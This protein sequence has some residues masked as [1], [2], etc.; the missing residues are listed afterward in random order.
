MTIDITV[1]TENEIRFEAKAFEPGKIPDV[2]RKLLAEFAGEGR[3]LLDVGPAEATMDG[4]V[5]CWVAAC[6]AREVTA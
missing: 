2:A 3:W 1:R 5:R 6:S 4:D